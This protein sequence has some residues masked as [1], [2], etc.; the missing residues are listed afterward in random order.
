MDSEKKEIIRQNF[1]SAEAEKGLSVALDGEAE[2]FKNQVNQGIAQL[3]KVGSDSWAILRIEYMNETG[4][5]VL[6][7][8]CYQGSNYLQFVGDVIKAARQQNIKIFRIHSKSA[9][10]GRWLIN[11]FGFSVEDKD[12]DEKIYILRV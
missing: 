5:P 10:I 7:G 11:D 12:A 8:C 9:G 4:A 2:Y 1:W 6:V 3:Y